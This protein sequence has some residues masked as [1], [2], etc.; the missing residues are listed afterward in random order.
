[1]T[2]SRRSQRK[3]SKPIAPPTAPPVTRSHPP[4][5]RTPSPRNP[6]DITTRSTQPRTNATRAPKPTPPS[7]PPAASKPAPS[8]GPPA[9]SKPA[10]SPQRGR[11]GSTLHR[12]STP[13]PPSA[14]RRGSRR[15]T[16]TGVPS[17]PVPSHRSVG[18]VP[19]QHTLSVLP[20]TTSINSTKTAPSTLFSPPTFMEKADATNHRSL[21]KSNQPVFSDVSESDESSF[22]PSYDDESLRAAVTSLTNVMT[23][24]DERFLAL[25][26]SLDPS[27]RLLTAPPKP[28]APPRVKLDLPLRSITSQGVEM[29]TSP[30]ILLPIDEGIQWLYSGDLTRSVTIMECALPTLIRRQPIYHVKCAGF[31]EAEY[32]VHHDDLF[33][34][35]STALTLD[36]DGII[37]S[38]GS[39][40]SATDRLDLHATDGNFLPQDAVLWTSLDSSQ[41]KLATLQTAIDKITLH[42]DSIVEIK[43]L[44]DSISTAITGASKTGLLRLPSLLDLTPTCSLRD[45]LMPPPSYPHYDRAK[46]CYGNIASS[47]AVRLS[48]KDFSVNAPKARLVLTAIANGK[49]DGID[50]LYYL[51]KSR[52]PILGATGFNAYAEILNLEITEGMDL[53]T[54]IARAQDIQA[55]LDLSGHPSSDNSLLQQFLS[56]LMKSNVHSYVSGTFSSFNRFNKHNGNMKR[57][58]DDSIDS[59]SQ[60]LLDGGA[61]TVLHLTDSPDNATSDPNN[62]SAFKQA[63]YRHKARSNHSRLQF[64]AM[65]SHTDIPSTPTTSPTTEN[66]STTAKS[67]TTTSAPS[68]DDAT[69]DS[70][71]CTDA[72]I[73]AA[74]DLVTPFL[75]SLDLPDA[76]KE[77]LYDNLMLKAMHHSKSN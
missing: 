30:V 66:G 31:A 46:A 39:V 56:Q 41:F 53:I 60:D 11:Q 6:P 20:D 63:L 10:T 68:T 18:S 42:S 23:K 77:T 38:S 35:K 64:G 34:P 14:L 5:T 2:A 61:P 50:Q 9:A 21:S 43:R 24:F 65:S 19:S 58:T 51:Y 12:H 16:R 76:D 15:T 48:H 75:D 47:I 52:L 72:D 70:D 37:R 13:R 59:I 57:Y 54:F 49:M 4:A 36:E 1:M 22:L 44:H 26:K 73:K 45:K 32:D 25:E 40:L 8:S 27:T 71:A 62:T 17:T 74:S 28:P 55:Q 33:I 7:G 3:S 67:S 69:V 29:T